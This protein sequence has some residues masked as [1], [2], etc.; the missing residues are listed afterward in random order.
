MS[1]IAAK[2][3][4]SAASL[5]LFFPNKRCLLA[6][7]LLQIFESEMEPFIQ[8]IERM[9]TWEDQLKTLFVKHLA[10]GS[11]DNTDFLYM[12][13]DVFRPNDNDVPKE[14]SD[15]FVKCRGI[16]L[17]M[18]KEILERAK[19]EEQLDFD[20]EYMAVTLLGGME[21]MH[22]YS[23][24]G[25]LSKIPTDFAEDAVRLVKKQK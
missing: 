24:L 13:S 20:T 8:Q 12:L 15:R 1:Q 19:K 3:E 4:L 22:H 25:M 14:M 21:A 2:A 10:F 5:Y 6:E 7:M 9:S 23:G 18:L 17:E 16:L 11:D